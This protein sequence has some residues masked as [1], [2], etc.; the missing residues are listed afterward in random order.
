MLRGGLPASLDFAARDAFFAFLS[1][2]P[3]QT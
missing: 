3:L 1:N 2:I